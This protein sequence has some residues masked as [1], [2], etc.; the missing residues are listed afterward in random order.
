MARGRISTAPALDATL[1]PTRRAGAG[2]RPRAGTA[3]RGVPGRGQGAGV[4]QTPG[5]PDWVEAPDGRWYPPGP[6]QGGPPPGGPYGQ[7]RYGAES[8]P[9]YGQAP[10]GQAPYGQAPYGK[11]PYG[12][13]PYRQAHYGR[14]VGGTARL[15]SGRGS[16][17]RLGRP[18]VGPRR[19][20]SATDCPRPPT[21]GDNSVDRAHEAGGTF[22][23]DR[24]TTTA[25]PRDSRRAAGSVH[26]GTEPSTDRPRSDSTSRQD[27]D[28]RRRGLSTLRTPPSTT[29]VALS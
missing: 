26:H 28:L 8:H 6:P 29:A 20:P 10:D 24:W 9:P 5:G 4:S 13:S 1:I 11:A 7:A 27:A 25:Q 2:R 21:S 19:A 3:R 22:R 18:D 16:P 23:P 17:T 12:Q 15:A 14:T